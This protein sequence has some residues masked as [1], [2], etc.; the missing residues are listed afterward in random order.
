MPM[1]A[2]GPKR[3]KASVQPALPMLASRR[4]LPAVTLPNWSRLLTIDAVPAGT[5]G[6][7]WWPLMVT[8][9]VGELKGTAPPPSVPDEDCGGK[10]A[11]KVSAASSVTP[12]EMR[13]M[14][15][16]RLARWRAGEPARKLAA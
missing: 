12:D 8:S 1:P 3:S 5:D 16:R 14:Q 2:L 4:K 10:Q 11:E 15:P 13:P 6:P 9:S 7:K